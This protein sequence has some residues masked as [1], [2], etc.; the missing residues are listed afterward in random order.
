[1]R[2]KWWTQRTFAIDRRAM[3]SVYLCPVL[4]VLACLGVDTFAPLVPTLMVIGAI[5][6]IV[7]LLN[8]SNTIGMTTLSILGHCIVYV[9]Y[10]LR[11]PTNVSPIPSLCLTAC[12]LSTYY[13]LD[14]WPYCISPM[15]FATVASLVILMIH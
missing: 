10:L 12:V 14:I 15:E 1:M 8:H 13:A 11:P 2:E 5:T 9:P 7:F 4:L 6:G 3:S